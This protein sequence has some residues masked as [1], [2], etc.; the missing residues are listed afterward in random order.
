MSDEH[1]SDENGQTKEE[2]QSSQ[3]A[4]DE[5]QAPQ[6]PDGGLTA[7][8]CVLGCGACYFCSYG[9]IKYALPQ[10]HGFDCALLTDTAP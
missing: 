3:V 4:Q 1:F 10:A 2:E 7:W 9:W 6:H 5:P 8:L